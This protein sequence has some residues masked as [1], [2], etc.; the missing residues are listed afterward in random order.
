MDYSAPIKLHDYR[1]LGDSFRE[2]DCI[3][4]KTQRWVNRF[5]SMPILERKAIMHAIKNIDRETIS[6]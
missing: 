1:Y 6:R 3:K 4:L 2:R 5:R